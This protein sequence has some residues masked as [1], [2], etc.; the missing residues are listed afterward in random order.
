MKITILIPV[1][2]EIAT[3]EELLRRVY[4][5][6]LPCEKEIIIIDDFS[7]DGTRKL[8]EKIN[9]PGVKKI[10]HPMNL[11]KGAAIRNSISSISGDLV[12]IQ[13]ADLEYHPDEYPRIIQPILEG[14]ADVVFGSRFI[15]THRCFL[16]THYAGNKVVNMITNILFNTTLTDMM[17]GYKVFTSDVLRDLPLKSN[18]FGVEAEIT[19]AVC[20]K[21]LRVYEVPIS[22]SGRDYSEG[23][24]IKWTDFFITL[25]WLLY[26]KIR[27][28]GDV[29]YESL[30]KLR[31]MDK[32][33]RY[34]FDTIK[35]FLGERI[36][37]IDA[38]IGNLTR[39][40]LVN[41][42]LVVSTDTS[43]KT[44]AYLT[45]HLPSSSIF[46]VLQCDI[47]DQSIV[48]KLK[49]YQCDTAVLI[50]VLEH[51]END[52]NA[53]SVIGDALVP[54]GKV[55]IV[56]PAHAGLFT[57]FDRLRGYLRRYDQVSLSSLLESRGFSIEKIKNFNI[58]GMAGWW[59]DFKV[60]RKKGISKFQLGV[61]NQLIWFTRIL[62]KLFPD[63]GLSL[64]VVAKKK[65]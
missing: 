51:V 49:P 15:G 59:W 20:R 48:D 28:L 63:H 6:Q 58:I 18:R 44:L 50:N 12:I 29:P 46:K 10:F 1:Y 38:G 40:L 19:G 31:G 17:T 42:E 54:H 26:S 34:I 4:A 27:I 36:L 9:D 3:F 24:K 53:L 22:Y 5:V 62:D 14:K 43:A 52:G 57:E 45:Y 55:I 32:Y 61:Y 37:E 30:K 16:F 13:D 65:G 23:K 56:V 39:F 33:T 60:L 64:L 21:S 47:S 11:G 2:N 25:W 41:R 7:T 8:V 35:I